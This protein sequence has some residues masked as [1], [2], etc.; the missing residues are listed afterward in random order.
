M[1]S[2][3]PRGNTL[4]TKLASVNNHTNNDEFVRDCEDIFRLA[5]E[6]YERKTDKGVMIYKFN[7]PLLPNCMG[8]QP[9]DYAIGLSKNKRNTMDSSRY[10]QITA[11]DMKTV[12]SGKNLPLAQAIFANTRDY[13][14]MHTNPIKSINQAVVRHLP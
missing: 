8:L 4:L 1:F 2:V 12:Q 10:A 13:S 3:L 5:S 7:I 14:F 9:L 11:S 6:G